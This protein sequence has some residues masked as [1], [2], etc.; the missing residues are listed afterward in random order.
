[1]IHASTADVFIILS[2]QEALDTSLEG[3]DAS[4]NANKSFPPV[5]YVLAFEMDFSSLHEIFITAH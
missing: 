2:F 5:T 1:M 3:E 4:R